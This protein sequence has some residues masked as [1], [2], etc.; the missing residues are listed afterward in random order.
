[1]SLDAASEVLLVGC[2]KMGQA[3]LKGWL[4]GGVV[5]HVTAVDPAGAP[6]L[7]G[8][9][10]VTLLSEAAMLPADYRADVIVVAVKPQYMDA[11]MPP[12]RALVERGT[13]L[14]SI[15][16]GKTFASFERYFGP[17]AMVRAMPNTPAAIGRGVSVA[18]PN[19]RVPDEGRALCDRLLRA[20]GAVEWAE[21]E[22]IID[23]VTAVSGSGPAYVF[24]IV[25]ALAAAGAKAGL[26][27]EMAMRLA[28]ATI[29]GAG[30]LVRLSPDSAEQLRKNVTS[31]AGTTQAALDVLM[32][33]DGIQPLFDRAVA[34]AANRSRELAG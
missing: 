3:L 11:A 30:E 1:M 2:G 5:R 4:D 18:V 28:R 9:A 25:E 14:L 27:P 12:Y 23:L 29:A 31:P 20:V 26:P 6:A 8:E 24:L 19:A 21:D 15:A 13:L 32:A 7:A 33:P 22:A 34:A 16:A 17:A 10:R